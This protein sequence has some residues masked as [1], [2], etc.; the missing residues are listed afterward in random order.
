M[1]K[2]SAL[3]LIPLLA[4]CGSSNTDDGS[5]SDP[6]GTGEVSYRL[7][8]SSTW[9]ANTFPTQHPSNAHF[10]PIVGA[11]HSA[12]T[13]IW[14]PDDQPSTTGIESVAETGSTSS[15]KSELNVQKEQGYVDTVFSATGAFNSPGEQSIVFKASEQHS[16]VSAISM[17]APSPDW[18][19]G[20]RDVELFEN[21]EWIDNKSFDLKLYDA[22]TDTANNFSS[23]N[24]DGGDRIIKLV[25]TATGNTD[26]TDGVNRNSGAFVGQFVIQRL[27]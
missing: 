9:A 13:I 3:F 19:V 2:Y 8:F 12:Q 5:S 17:L 4:A 6:Q 25:T 16:L 10:S 21:G 15:F 27:E 26:F 14:R 24:A 22:G 20:I 11:T 23:A 7:T 1:L 18:F